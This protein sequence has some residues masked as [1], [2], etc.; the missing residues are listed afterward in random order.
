[1]VPNRST[2]ANSTELNGAFST[3]LPPSPPIAYTKRAAL[4]ASPEVAASARRPTIMS[5]PAFG[6]LRLSD[7]LVTPTAE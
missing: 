4:V 2:G 6:L 7:E 1:M 5:G 3:A